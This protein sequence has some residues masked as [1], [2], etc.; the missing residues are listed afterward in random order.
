MCVQ[1]TVWSAFGMYSTQLCFLNWTN[2][3][4]WFVRNFD[5]VQNNDVVWIV[6]FYFAYY[7]RNM[8]SLL[9][10][11]LFKPIT[12]FSGTDGIMRNIPHIQ[13]NFDKSPKVG[14]NNIWQMHVKLYEGLNCS[15]L[16]VSQY[17]TQRL[18]TILVKV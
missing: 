17:S 6:C 1:F 4:F 14:T 10:T 13:V 8:L 7:S 18:V 2:W 5:L 3:Y 16:K 11:T 15:S 9:T 12:M